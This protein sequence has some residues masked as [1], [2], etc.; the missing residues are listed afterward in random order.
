VQF[1]VSGRLSYLGMQIDISSEGTIIDMQFYTKK[2]LEG[3]DVPVR[4]LLG[5]NTTFIVD[6]VAK[7]LSEE[8]RKVFHSRV[9]KLLFLAR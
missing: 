4:E 2:V 1:E 8:E 6:E 9:A 3:M 7:E 5:M